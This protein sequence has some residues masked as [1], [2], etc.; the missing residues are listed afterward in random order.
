MHLG[1]VFDVTLLRAR[2][3][4]VSGSRTVRHK[5]ISSFLTLPPILSLSPDCCSLRVL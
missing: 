1:G 2:Y 3:I 5:L 4:Y